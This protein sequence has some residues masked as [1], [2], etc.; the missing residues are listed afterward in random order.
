MRGVA[1][2]VSRAEGPRYRPDIDGLRAIAV[3]AVVFYHAGFGGISGG[4]AGVDI[5]FVISGYLI[6]ATIAEDLRVGQ[7]SIVAFYERR[8]R[9]I[10]PA[11]FAMAFFC[12]VAATILFDPGHLI[13]FGKSLLATT[14]F[15]SNVY[16]RAIAT[17]R[18]YF[19]SG[20]DT[21]MLLHTW[22]LAVEEQFYIVFPAVLLLLRR[23]GDR[24][25]KAGLIVLA[26]LSFAIGAASVSTRQAY[27]FYIVVPRAWE[28]LAGSL[29]ALG[30][31]P[32]APSRGAREIAA[33][34]G[35]GLIAFAIVRLDRRTLFPGAAALLPVAGAWLVIFAGR[36]GPTWVGRALSLRPVVYVGLISY[37]LYLWHWPVV[38]IVEAL[39]LDVP[40]LGGAVLIVAVS[41]GAA[42]LSY[43]FIE[44]PFRGRTPLLERRQVFAAAASCMATAAACGLVFVAGHGL[45]QRYDAR[46]NRIIAQNIERA[47]DHPSFDCLNWRRSVHRTEDIFS[48]PIGRGERKIAFWGDS[49]VDQ[50]RPLIARLD[51]EGLFGARGLFFLVSGGCMPATGVE[52][53][54]DDYHCAAFSDAAIARIEQDDVDTVFI[55][56]SPLSE[57][58]PATTCL[59]AAGACVPPSS[60]R[61][62]ADRIVEKVRDMAGK[63]RREGKTV[64]VMLPL[65]IYN[66]P[67]PELE[68]S[69]AAL[70]SLRDILRTHDLVAGLRREDFTYTRERLRAAATDIGAFV[71]DPRPTLCK[72]DDCLYARD[73]VSMYTDSSHIATHAIGIFHDGLAGVFREALAPRKGSG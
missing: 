60:G 22:S 40:T 52:R 58:K 7:F 15:A 65:P 57:V 8:V 5:F 46:T 30:V 19:E 51:A 47:D 31:A 50:L 42:A 26:L 38:V 24:R 35:V 68:I 27:A 12:V 16:F 37:S 13:G 6:M 54:D 63:F 2:D 64:I 41:L 56:F 36:T 44:R 20:T 33:A 4:Y 14:V 66:L 9:R 61:K 71:Y 45:Q 67:I 32:P 11:L 73:D 48:C 21:Q 70:G 72:G 69:R 43:R 25:M 28:L 34:L 3:L 39:S 55:G 10:F 49:H 59:I 23:L 18:G 53:I 62:A 1:E 17:G 29:L